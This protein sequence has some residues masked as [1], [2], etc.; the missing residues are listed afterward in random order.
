MQTWS[1]GVGESSRNVH[2]R[3]KKKHHDPE[4]QAGPAHLNFCGNAQRCGQQRNPDEYVQNKCQGT[5]EGTSG[6]MNFA[7]E[8][9]SAPKTAKR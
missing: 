4:Q 1:L 3:H 8:R 9:C 5:N 2:H 7:S 6:M